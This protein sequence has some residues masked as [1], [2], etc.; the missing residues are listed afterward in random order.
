MS[1]PHPLVAVSAADSVWMQR[2]YIYL[3]VAAV[4]LVIVL[5]FLKRMMAPIGALIQAFAAAALVAVAAFVALAMLVI[6]ALMSVR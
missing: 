1:F 5:R 6:A 4:C 3:A 2:P